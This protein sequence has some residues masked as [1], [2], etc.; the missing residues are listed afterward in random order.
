MK[1][2]GHSDIIGRRGM[3]RDA[4][5]LRTS[6]VGV[7]FYRS[8]DGEHVHVST[9]QM[10]DERGEGLILRGG[11]MVESKE[12]RQ[13]HLEAEGAYELL[14]NSLKG[15]RDQHGHWPGVALHKTSRFDRGELDGFNRAVDERVIDY[16]DIVWVQRSMIRLY[17]LG[18]YPPLRGSLVRFDKDRALLYTRG[19]GEFFRTHPR[20]YVPRPLMLTCQVQGQ[21]LHH[22]A[23]EMLA[24]TKMNWNNTQFDN[25]MPITI[26]AAKPVGEVLKYVPEGQEIAPRYSHYM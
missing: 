25:G 4:R 7:S 22:V 20:M 1:K 11:R 2:I 18:V 26:A 23:A 10:S 19:S 16:A 15:F 24:L 9:A 6:L 17:R 5:Q 13:P 21:R 12:D 8:T 3:A 14:C